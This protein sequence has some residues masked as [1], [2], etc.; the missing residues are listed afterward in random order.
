MQIVG[1]L[2][3][4]LLLP[5][6]EASAA[7]AG[8]PSLAPRAPAS[9]EAVGTHDGIAVFRREIPGS[10]IIAFR[11]ECVIP[12]AI[13]KIV[14]VL[15]ETSRQKEWLDRLVEARVVRA[16]SE[17]E[18]VEYNR[19]SAPW[20]LADRDFLFAWSAALD[21]AN[22]RVVVLMHSVEDPAA[23]RRPGI[24]R[25]ELLQ[26]TWILSALGPKT[27]QVSV[28]IQADPRGMIPKW[29]VNL[30]QSSWPRRTLEGIR[31][32]VQ[33]PDVGEHPAFEAWLSRAF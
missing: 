23:P 18:R 13:G 29:I 32:Q 25:G 1:F 20:P 12:A 30:F 16:V 28:E 6:P 21:A 2:L 24:I 14:S 7:A 4:A 9:W 26:S 8:S 33:K 22:K 27:T 5:A 3:V 31:R 10:A 19:T 15:T 17:R 11:G